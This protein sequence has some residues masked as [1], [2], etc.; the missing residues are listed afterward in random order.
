MT[1]LVAGS[2]RAFIDAMAD[3]VEGA[4]VVVVP[5]A[6]A[7]VGAAQAA[8]EIATALEP[9]GAD[10]EALMVLDRAGAHE[11]ALVERV[12]RADYVVLTDGASL[13]ARAV[14]RDSAFGD[15][16][17]VARLVAIGSV[18][19]VLGSVMIDPRGGAPTIGLGYRRGVVLTVPATAE[20]LERTRRLHTGDEPLVVVGARGVL[21]ESDGRWRVV[22]ADDVEVTHGDHVASLD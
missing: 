5:T 22:V 11:A 17:A 18:A 4:S 21:A 1:T 6:A 15:A 13:H 8:L 3:E 14:W 9:T 16:L 7:F 2:L 12:A 10:V 19:T 20:Q